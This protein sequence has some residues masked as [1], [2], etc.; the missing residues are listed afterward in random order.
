MSSRIPG[1]NPAARHTI[2]RNGAPWS[3]VAF[4]F[5]M[6]GFLSPI[7]PASAQIQRMGLVLPTDNQ[8]LL[9]GNPETF[10]QFVDRLWEG[11]RS[12]VWEGGRFGFV[13]DPKRL[14]TGQILFSR[15]HEGLDIRPVRRDASG[16]P[17]DEVRSISAGQ[18]VHT[19][20]ESGRSNYGRY[21]VIR[22]DWGYGPFFS[23]YAHLREIRVAVGDRVTA[24][25]VLGIMG[26]TGSGIDRRRAHTHVELNL[27]LSSRFPAWHDAHFKTPNHHGLYNG[28]NLTGLD[29]AGLYLEHHRNP[30]LTV[31]QFVTQSTPAFSVAVPGTAEMEILEN[32]AWLCLDP[33]SSRPP[34]WEI[35]FSAWG[36]PLSVKAGGRVIAQPAALWVKD[37]PMPH[38][39][40]TRGCITGSTAKPVLTAEGMQFV[41]LV[42]GAF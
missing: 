17:L 25:S 41:Q 4:T 22:H 12:E 13:R 10:Y 18:V 39:F 31:A 21:V 8:S 6:F 9:E 11:Q 40:Q 34:S 42:S 2:L 1:G 35:T 3:A 37:S 19:A 24:H 7:L 5:L 26:Y 27:F 33:P 14:T 38:Y 28:L 30:S 32:Y 20:H 29:L 16:E 23:L 36:L 15:F